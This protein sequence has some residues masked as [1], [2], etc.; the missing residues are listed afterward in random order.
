M[1]VARAINIH[2]LICNLFRLLQHELFLIRAFE[3]CAARGINRFALLVH[4]VVVFEQMFSRFEVLCFDGLLRVL[5]SLA[6]QPRFDRNAFR[7]AQPVHQRLHALAA[8]NPQQIV[9]ERKEESRRSRIALPSSASSQLIV[10]A[11]RLMT[12]GAE[13]VQ[14]AHRHHFVVFSAALLRELVVDRL[15]LIQRHLINLAFLLEQ[16]HWRL[17]PA[18]F[19]SPQRLAPLPAPRAA[20][21]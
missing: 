1:L 16:N 20:S 13:N 6:D 18:P 3:N 12:L 8:E 17:L 2:Q 15:P 7:H 11:P 14:S 9:L 4:H 21:A 19:P 10:D 5:D